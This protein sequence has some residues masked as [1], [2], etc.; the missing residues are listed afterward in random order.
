VIICLVG[1]SDWV[2]PWGLGNEG[3]TG[4]NGNDANGGSVHERV[5]V[6]RRYLSRGLSQEGD[7]VKMCCASSRWQ[8]RSRT[9]TLN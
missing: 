2:R 9:K 5:S 4:H 6:D 3:I 7:A 8:N 1:L